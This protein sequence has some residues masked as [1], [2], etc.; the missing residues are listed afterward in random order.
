MLH[1]ELSRTDRLTSLEALFVGVMLVVWLDRPQGEPVMK[2][3][4][5]SADGPCPG[6]FVQEWQAATNAAGMPLAHG[7]SLPLEFTAPASTARVDDVSIPTTAGT[8]QV[9]PE[10][11]PIRVHF[12]KSQCFRAWDGRGMEEAPSLY[13]T[14]KVLPPI[15]TRTTVSKFPFLAPILQRFVQQQTDRM[16]WLVIMFE[17]ML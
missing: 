17:Y 5:K 9:S 4:W 7:P 12:T 11:L 10:Q 6:G 8:L 13:L 14:V 16:A 1:P 15:H 3:E 2:V